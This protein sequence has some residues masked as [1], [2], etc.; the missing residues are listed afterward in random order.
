MMS[1]RKLC[2]GVV[3][4]RDSEQEVRFHIKGRNSTFELREPEKAFPG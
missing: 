2:K 4:K 1:H 3:F